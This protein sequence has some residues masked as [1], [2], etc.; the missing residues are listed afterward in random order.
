MVGGIAR[1]MKIKDMQV[2][3]LMGV[4]R[5]LKDKPFVMIHGRELFLYGYE[6]LSE[7]FDVFI[8]Y[9][10]ALIDR[11]KQYVRYHKELNLNIIPESMEIGP[12]GGI[13]EGMKHATSEYVFVVGC[14]MPLLNVGII[15]FLYDSVA[16]TK[17]D[18]AVPVHD[19][20]C[21]EPLCS[22]YR[23]K[24]VLEVLDHNLNGNGSGRGLKI[25]RMIEGMDM[26]YVPVNDL[27]EY[28]N[29]LLT[30]KNVNTPEDIVKVEKYLRV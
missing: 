23:R 16:G 27:K 21:I 5:R 18:G 9:E 14:D 22:V 24:K 20:G 26:I 17:R 6:K 11:L 10:A 19:D 3:M 25:A 4:S 15:K 28:D 7:L 8:V 1:E 13:Y 12:L 29:S 2:I 30:F